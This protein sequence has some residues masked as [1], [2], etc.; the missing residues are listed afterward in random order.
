MNDKNARYT[1]DR[2]GVVLAHLHTLST[3]VASFDN[4]SNMTYKRLLHPV[5]DEFKSNKTKSSELNEVILQCAH[6]LQ[7]YIDSIEQIEQKPAN[8]YLSGVIS[9]C[10]DGIRAML[11]EV[12]ATQYV[13]EYI[14]F[15]ILEN[16]DK[17]NDRLSDMRT[18]AEGGNRVAVSEIAKK[19][20][21][22]HMMALFIAT[23]GVDASL[24]DL[25]KLRGELTVVHLLA[26]NNLQAV[27][28]KKY[29]LLVDAIEKEA[30]KTALLSKEVFKPH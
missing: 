9:G 14:H 23:E 19:H 30:E 11:H 13:R 18:L 6:T 1:L 12:F 4:L 16:L 22:E 7:S 28:T 27:D 10:G 17:L 25:H 20:L 8:R 26:N 2:T 21:G 5:L 15:R 29:M 3:L 24:A